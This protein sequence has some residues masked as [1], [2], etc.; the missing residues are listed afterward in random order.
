MSHELLAHLRKLNE[1]RTKGPWEFKGTEDSGGV[2]FVYAPNAAKSWDGLEFIAADC[3]M[4]KN[5]EFIAAIANNA[6]WLIGCAAALSYI[7]PL[8][9]HAEKE[10]AHAKANS[11]SFHYAAIEQLTERA[12]AALEQKP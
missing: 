3:S 12:R 6:D 2:R 7:F 10:M 4:A 5:G 8:L 9:E 1:A 11:Y